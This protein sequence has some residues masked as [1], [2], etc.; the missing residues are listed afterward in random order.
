MR[1]IGT[2]ACMH[3]A[4]SSFINGVKSPPVFSELIDPAVGLFL[5][6]FWLWCAYRFATGKAGEYFA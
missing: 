2:L 5:T 3:T 4:L 1:I 6:G